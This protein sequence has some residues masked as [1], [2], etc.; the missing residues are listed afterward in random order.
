MKFFVS[1]R[2]DKDICYALEGYPSFDVSSDRN[3]VDIAAFVHEETSKLV[4]KRRLLHNSPAK[5]ELIGL[6]IE[7]VSRGAD[8]M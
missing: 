8:G 1:S 6:I 5:D 4:Q 3:A 2:D 7:K